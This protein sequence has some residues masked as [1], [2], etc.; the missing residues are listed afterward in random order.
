MGYCVKVVRDGLGD[1]LERAKRGD[2]RERYCGC[3]IGLR[4]SV[5]DEPDEMYAPGA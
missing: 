2:V 4:P 1:F 5:D 3:E